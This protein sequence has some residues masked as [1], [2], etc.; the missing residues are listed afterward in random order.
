MRARQE[1]RAFR[2][3]QGMVSHRLKKHHVDYLALV[4][5]SCSQTGA[6]ESMEEGKEKGMRKNEGWSQIEE[7]ITNVRQSY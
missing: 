5:D 3:S 2:A 7:R 4:R 6:K 1:G